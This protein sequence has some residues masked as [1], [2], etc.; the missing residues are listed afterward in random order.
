MKSLGLNVIVLEPNENYP[1]SC[2]VEDTAVIN[3]KVAIIN[4]LGV[5]SRQGEEIEIEQVLSKF[6]SYIER[7][8]P[9]GTLEGGDLL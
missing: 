1:D 7:I 4:H 5:L 6:F 8:Q 3:E 9:P 2:F